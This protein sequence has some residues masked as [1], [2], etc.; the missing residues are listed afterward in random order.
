MNTQQK[1]IALRQLDM[2]DIVKCTNGKEYEFVRMKQSKFIGKRDGSSYDVPVEMFVEL[3]RKAEKT[4]FDPSSLQEGELFYI[5]NNKQ[6]PICLR[7]KYMINASKIQAENPVTG[8]GYRVSTEMAEGSIR[9]FQR[10]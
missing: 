9:E 10:A 1:K 8:Q 6:E 7:F 3:V 4:R 5:L 2:G